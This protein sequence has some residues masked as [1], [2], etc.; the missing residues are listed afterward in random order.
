ML[1]RLP[2]EMV[3]RGKCPAK[4]VLG[5]KT[6]PTATSGSKRVGTLGLGVRAGGTQKERDSRWEQGLV[7][8]AVTEMLWNHVTVAQ[9]CRCS[10]SH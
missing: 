4:R 5:H 8:Q 6:S 7:F 2:L 10:R 1:Q 9:N 3:L